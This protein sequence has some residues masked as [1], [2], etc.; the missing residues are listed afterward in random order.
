[1]NSQDFKHILPIHT[2]QWLHIRTGE[3]LSNVIAEAIEAAHYY[4]RPVGFHFNETPVFVWPSDHTFHAVYE[5]WVN[6]RTRT[7]DTKATEQEDIDWKA[8][9]A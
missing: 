3:Q 5:R 2:V 7:L 6:A 9:R 4:E 1:M 8:K